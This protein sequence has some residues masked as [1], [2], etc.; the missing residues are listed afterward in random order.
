MINMELARQRGLSKSQ[1]KDLNTLHHAMALLVEQW[2]FCC[3]NQWEAGTR[4]DWR[5]TIRRL[6]YLMQDAWGFDRDKS[7]HTHWRRF[8]GLCD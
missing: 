3:G 5:K 6:E 4:K 2:E 7:K 1:I 8:P